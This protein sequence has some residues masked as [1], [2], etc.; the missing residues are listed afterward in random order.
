MDISV[1]LREGAKQ[2]VAI[3]RRTWAILSSS[4]ECHYTPVLARRLKRVKQ[5]R[6]ER[7]RWLLGGRQARMKQGSSFEKWVALPGDRPWPDCP[8]MEIVPVAPCLS[9]SRLLMVPSTTT[10][11]CG[12]TLCVRITARRTTRS[13][14][15][16]RTPALGSTMA[17]R[18]S[19][20]VLLV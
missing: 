1:E 6:R 4:S 5:G 13:T 20:A 18:T 7:M 17:D 3:T 19:C 14:P 12:Q 11:A 9:R 10:A 16:P 8:Y 15:P 2:H